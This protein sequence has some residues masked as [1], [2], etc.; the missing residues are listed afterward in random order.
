MILGRMRILGPVRA[1]DGTGRGLDTGA[2]AKG[3]LKALW[4]ET[5]G[6]V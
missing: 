3:L 5:V 1:L 6:A 4:G 2:P